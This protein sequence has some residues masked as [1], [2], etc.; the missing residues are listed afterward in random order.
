M[1]N[2]HYPHRTLV[3]GDR[4]HEAFSEPHKCPH[5]TVYFKVHAP[6]HNELRCGFGPNQRVACRSFVSASEAC[7][8]SEPNWDAASNK[9]SLR[10]SASPAQK[11]PPSAPSAPSTSFSWYLLHILGVQNIDI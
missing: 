5:T 1:L 11:G 8:V 7:Q 6:C 4:E 10:R 3:S 2:L 9:R